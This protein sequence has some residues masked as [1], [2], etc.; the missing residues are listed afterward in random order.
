MVRMGD[1]WPT[2]ATPPMANPVAARTVSGSARPTLASPARAGDLGHVD[3]VPAGGQDEQGEDAPVEVGRR[4][5]EGVGDLGRGDAEGV[6]RGLGGADGVGEVADRRGHLWAARAASTRATPGWLLR[7]WATPRSPGRSLGR[8]SAGRR[9]GSWSLP[10][11]VAGRS[12]RGRRR[13]LV[14]SAHG[15]SLG[16][17]P[18]G[19]GDAG[20]TSSARGGVP[21]TIVRTPVRSESR[22]SRHGPQ[23]RRAGRGRGGGRGGPRASRGTAGATGSGRSR[24]AGASGGHGGAT[25]ART[26]GPGGAPSASCGGSR[27]VP[28]AATGVFELGADGAGSAAGPARGPARH[29]RGGAVVAAA[30]RGLTGRRR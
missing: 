22:R 15:R 21:W 1:R 23:V 14:G 17:P 13:C 10:R 29:V 2:G 7:S 30:G 18:S 6:G 20:L 16:R 24:P 26:T 8:S 27:R 9:V 5:D 4:E 19:G 28:G 12:P 3:P 25:S 11:S